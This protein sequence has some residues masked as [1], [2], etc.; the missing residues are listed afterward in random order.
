MRKIGV[1]GCGLRSDSYLRWLS[2]NH[3][4]EIELAAVADPDLATRSVFT[5]RYDP[6]G[7]AQ[8]FETGPELLAE[9]GSELDGL[10]IA[11]PNY[12][13]LESARPA[14]SL[15]IPLLLEKPVATSAEEASELWSAYV[16]SGRPPIMVGFVLR[17]APFYRALRAAVSAGRV[18]KLISIFATE[19]MGAP[20]TSLFMR[21]WRRQEALAGPFIN[22]KCSHD[23]DVLSMLVGSQP[24]R[25]TSFA[26]RTR[27]H[28]IPGAGTN[29]SSCDIRERCRYDAAKLPK[30]TLTDRVAAEAGEI[31]NDSCVFS[32]EVT[33][34][35]HQVVNLEYQS[36]VLATFMVTMDQ[37]RT[38]RRIIVCGEDGQL[39]GDFERDELLLERWEAGQTVREVVPVEH[40]ASGHGGADSIIS[41]R[42]VDLLLGREVGSEA[43]LAEGINACLVGFAA[44][45]SRSEGIV[46]PVDYV[47]GW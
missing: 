12:A 23:F 2:A 1:I 19:L 28:P 34:P 33:I 46:A 17:Y 6:D 7:V 29:C 47:E 3:G 43:G 42:F 20:L 24:L 41:R 27:F 45:R 14:M 31:G 8:R 11:T 21:G 44:E 39:F 13:H 30:Y 26:D 35:D 10:I 32:D 40:D 4:E 18:G 38:S 36:G 25:V 5:E 16:E 37:P 15:G 9:A 22:E